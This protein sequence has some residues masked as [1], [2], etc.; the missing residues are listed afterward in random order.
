MIVMRKPL[1]VLLVLVLTVPVCPPVAPE[2]GLSLYPGYQSW[3]LFQ[4]T[5]LNQ[6]AILGGRGW[7]LP[8]IA[9][10]PLLLQGYVLLPARSKGRFCQSH[11]ACLHWLTIRNTRFLGIWSQLFLDQRASRAYPQLHLHLKDWFMSY[12]P[13][14][15]SSEWVIA[16]SSLLFKRNAQC[17]QQVQHKGVW[18]SDFL[19]S[20]FFSVS[21]G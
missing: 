2:E 3:M 8:N 5:Q 7:M 4:L 15:P 20:G 16:L 17:V 19:K 21:H 12:L 11:R 13:M 9:V 10:I 18:M 14:R 1:W 6:G